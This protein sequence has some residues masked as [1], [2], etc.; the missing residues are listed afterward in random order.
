[1]K[2]KTIVLLIC[3]GTV[4]VIV[5]KLITNK[6]KI[7]AANKVAPVENFRIPVSAAG[8]REEEE[9][10]KLLKTGKLAPV[11][12]AKVLSETSGNLKRLCFSLGDHV[13]Q[14]Q[15]LALI[16][17]RLLQLELQ[18]AE[19]NVSRLKDDVHTYTEL[20]KGN[21][22]TKRKAQRDTPELRRRH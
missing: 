8:V 14:G 16:D 1:M 6:Q 21:A 17:T 19:F 5:L 4:L 7:N 15:M 13:Q 22:A 9:E 12:E 2:K 20:F 11:T 18:K 10:A 3:A